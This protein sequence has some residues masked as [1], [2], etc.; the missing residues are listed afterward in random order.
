MRP[1]ILFLFLIVIACSCKKEE[2]ALNKFGDTVLVTIAD[3]QD[4]RLGD[5][6]LPYLSNQNPQYRR[7]A[8]LA[9][10]SLQDSN[11]VIHL[12]K[13]LFNDPDTHVRQAAAYAIGQTP[14][15]NSEQ[16]LRKAYGNE[17]SE[18]VLKELLEAYGKV[19][20]E[21]KLNSSP[22]NPELSEALAWSYYRMAV[23]GVSNAD[24]NTKAGELLKSP[25]TNTR[26]GAAHY[27]AR[28]A[29]DY[30]THEK[31]LIETAMHDS[32][33]EVRMAAILALQKI[34]SD[35]SRLAAAYSIQ[36]DT[37][38]RVRVNAIRSLQDFPFTLTKPVL[39][40][41]LQDSNNNVG[42]TASETIKNSISKD[43]W[44]EISSLARANKH[45]RIQANLF[46]AALS[47]SN[48]KELAEEIRSV[49]HTT[50]NS[51][52]KAALLTALQHSIM[53]YGFV[54]EQLLNNDEPVIKVAAALSLVG[55]NYRE[56]FDPALRLQFAQ[57]YQ[58]SIKN[59]DAAVI[60]IVT[61]ALADS[62][63]GY[64]SIIKNYNFLKEARNNL[65]LPRDFEAILPLERAIAFFEGREMPAPPE[66]E[67]NHPIP[68]DLVKRV[69]RDQKA[70]IKTSKGNITIRLWVEEAPGS[71][72]NFITLAL[73]KYYDDK[74]FH[75]VVPNFV[76]QGGCPRGDGWGSED[77]S[78]RSEFLPHPYKTGSIGMAS[79]GKDTEGTQWFIT[80]SPTPHLE[81]R[82]TR[83]AEVEEGMDI[84][85]KIEVGDRI[86]SVDIIHFDSL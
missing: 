37:D 76:V 72:A 20:R 23:R 63:L 27:F 13:L 11:F 25:D 49:Y 9:F 28:G 56:N 50:S 55:M 15:L 81:G 53:S 3:F 31:S 12:E 65:N 51:Y 24:L 2:R 26:L 73:N 6:L 17:I 46:E 40:K 4:R 35:S 41:A 10:G 5:S 75:R 71:V 59:G 67:F 85:H 60:G 83:F 34:K 70:L 69:P 66:N 36:N 16:V 18:F 45:W 52:Q 21:W 14:G 86:V 64:K 32:S 77:Y 48:H 74:F 58:E 57:L 1:V 42:V 29:K 8:T 80:H 84:V 54:R 7:S 33:G 38:Y 19:S 79:A 39:I 30:F 43:H 22:E 68:W 61:D 82:Y 62:T 47:V 78:I 44:I